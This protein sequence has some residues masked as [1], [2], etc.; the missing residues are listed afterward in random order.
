MGFFDRFKKQGEGID[1]NALQAKGDGAGLVRAYYAMGKDCL[2]KGDQERARMWLGR[3]EA[4]CSASDEVYEAVGDKTVDDIS[5]LLGELE[6]APVL[7]NRLTE[8]IGEGAKVLDDGQRALWGLLTFCRLEKLLTGAG[9]LPG[10]AVLGRT[11][12]VIDTLLDVFGGRIDPSA[13]DRLAAYNNYLYELSDSPAYTDLRQTLPVAEGEPFQL[14]DLNGE[15]VLTN[16]NLFVDYVLHGPLDPNK[17][18]DPKEAQAAAMLDVDEL[19]GVAACALLSDY[20]LRTRTGALEGMAPIQ[21]E[22]ERVRAD[23]EFVRSRPTEEA[24]RARAE[25]YRAMELLR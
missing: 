4:I 23:L 25:E 6:D 11:G 8:E 22:M 7:V 18:S 21:A 13:V 10:C 5:D 2:A 14:F 3:A 17:L 16:L 19:S 15:L 20:Y 24:F 1:L 9:T 12:E